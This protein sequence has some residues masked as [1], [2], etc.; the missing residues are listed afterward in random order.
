LGGEG[1]LG[2]GVYGQI[3][4]NPVQVD[5]R[6][7]VK[8]VDHKDVCYK[9]A[10]EFLARC[11]YSYAAD[12]LANLRGLSDWVWELRETKLIRNWQFAIHFCT[13]GQQ[14]SGSSLQL[15]GFSACEVKCRYTLLLTD[16]P[17][18]FGLTVGQDA[19]KKAWKANPAYLHQIYLGAMKAAD[20]EVTSKIIRAKLAEPEGSARRP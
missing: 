9:R 10:T 14:L 4:W 11:R 8:P 5:H 3:D 7:L 16:K 17:F 15:E 2:E 20:R 1:A 18:V 12:I 13:A 6:S 19:A